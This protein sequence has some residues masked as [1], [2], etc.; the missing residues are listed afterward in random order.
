RSAATTR[1]FWCEGRAPPVSPD[2]PFDE[3]TL[4]AVAV[5]AVGLEELAVAAFLAVVRVVLI[6][7]LALGCLCAD[8]CTAARNSCDDDDSGKPHAASDGRAT[9][10]VDRR[11]H[12][13]HHTT[14][15]SVLL[16]L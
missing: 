13:I 7:Q 11:A 5:R 14:K 4:A 10:R 3:R 2:R 9:T 8:R 12:I 1:L 16:S 6:L 15:Y